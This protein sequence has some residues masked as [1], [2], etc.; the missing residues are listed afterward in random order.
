MKGLKLF[1]VTLLLAISF[2]AYS[3][4]IRVK[5]GANLANFVEKDNDINYTEDYKLKPGFHLG[6]TVEFP[7][8]DMI[9][10]ET[11]L[12]LSSKGYK[13]EESETDY[14]YK[15]KLKML[16][17]DIPLTAKAYFDANDLRF[18]GFAGPQLGLALNGSVCV[19]STDGSDTYEEEFDID[20]G[21][22]ENTDHLKKME[23]GAIIGVG[24]EINALQISIHYNPGL[25]NISSNTNNGQTARN[26]VIGISASYLITEL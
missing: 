19:E 18:F 21:N 4:I 9:N 12:L 16:Y 20:F 2:S 8:T 5:G 26:N 25:I 13:Y 15:E 3:Q 10:F 6:P 17:I 14:E 23:I 7:L 24:V 11:G 1:T 22:D